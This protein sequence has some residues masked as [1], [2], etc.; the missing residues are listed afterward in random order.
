ML[1]LAIVLVAVLLAWLERGRT[2]GAARAI[3]GVLARRWTPVVVGLVWAA[4]VWWS[5]GAV[6]PRAVLHD[7]IAYVLQARLFAEG[8]WT[9]PAPPMADFFAQ[10]HVLVSPAIAAKY[11]PGHSLL[12][13][14][15]ELFGAPVLVVI[16]LA[17][18]RGAMVFALARRLSNG[19]VALGTSILLLH[20]DS[21]NWAASWFSE[22]TTA[23]LLLVSWYALLRWHQE[24]GRRWIVLL[25]LALGW[26]AISRPFSAA[27]FALPIGVVVL[28]DVVRDR[29]WRD[30]ALAV[31]VGTAI[32][33]IIPLWSWRTTGDA[34][35]WPV[36]QYTRDYM[37]YDHPHF[38][39]DTAQPRRELPPDLLT[40]A[41]SLIAEERNHTLARLPEIAVER[42]HYFARA[43]WHAPLL[44]GLL[45][46]VGLALAPS[47]V[48]VG[49]ATVV[50]ALLGYLAHPTWAYWTIYY[51]EVGVVLVFLSVAGLAQILRVVARRPRDGA[52]RWRGPLPPMA[53]LAAA[54]VLCAAFLVRPELRAYRAGHL[55]SALYQDRFD[56]AVAR[57]PG[58]AVLFVRHA[59]WHSPHLSLI[60]NSPDWERASVWIVPDRGDAR[61][62]AFLRAAPKRAPFLFDEERTMIDR[63][64]PGTAP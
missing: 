2:D 20:G 15:G 54:C 55:A 8:R 58:P 45:A 61:N 28:R 56:A 48:W 53:S 23:A 50:V 27:L 64:H 52:T 43:T 32:V 44:S 49:V 34:R 22:T 46:L 16:A 47:A 42:A 26:I 40:I 25:A 5:W 60:T 17:A 24:K 1:L 63:Y 10:P 9:A 4:V 31:A 35:L 38:G 14:L 19:T 39:V 7:E 33:A 3:E 62:L 21:L 18:L 51:M 13:A 41:P 11:P 36:T 30:L 29:R 37:P 59:S 57:I 12:L 6:H